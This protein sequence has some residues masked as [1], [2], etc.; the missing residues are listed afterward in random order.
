[1]A[2]AEK[3]L[4]VGGSKTLEVAGP[5]T[6]SA[7][8]SFFSL[9][10]SLPTNQETVDFCPYFSMFEFI[11]ELI[12]KQS[13]IHLIIMTINYVVCSAFLFSPLL[14]IP[15]ATSSVSAAHFNTRLEEC[16]YFTG[17]M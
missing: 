4:K 5:R 11:F 9:Q 14:S 2:L 13:S 6:L 17:V 7:A 16:F 15:V 12:I 10:H 8:H 1:M 3:A